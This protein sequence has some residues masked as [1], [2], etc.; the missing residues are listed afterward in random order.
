MDQFRATR[1]KGA[2]TAVSVSQD[3]ITGHRLKLQRE[4][5]ISDNTVVRTTCMEPLQVASKLGVESQ[6]VKTS[7]YP[8]DHK[9]MITAA[10][11]WP[12]GRIESR[13]LVQARH[14]RRSSSAREVGND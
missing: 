4:K 1:A 9:L 3:T 12:I 8:I 11:G 13:S 7:M 6:S 5:P 10:F 14:G 2:I